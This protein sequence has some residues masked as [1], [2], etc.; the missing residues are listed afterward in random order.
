MLTVEGRNVADDCIVRSGL[1]NSVDILSDDEMD[2]VQQANIPPNQNSTSS[3][4]MREEQPYVDARSR[5]QS[6][7]PAGP[8][9]RAQAC[10]II[11]K[12]VI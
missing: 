5:G 9:S 10:T 2:P 4:T 1:L 6:S 12:H 7:I 8:S 3:F 11:S